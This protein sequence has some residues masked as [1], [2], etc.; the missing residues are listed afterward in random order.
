MGSNIEAYK[1]E[2]E[3][4]VKKGD[5]MRLDLSL[6][7]MEEQEELD[8]KGKALAEKL[9]GTFEKAYQRWYTESSAVVR[10]LIPDRSSE[11]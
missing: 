3:V 7:H 5:D 11:F 8:K 9:H 2:L 4:L 10:Q 1:S 6:R